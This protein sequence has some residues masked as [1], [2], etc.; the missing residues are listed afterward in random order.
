MWPS[1]PVAASSDPARTTPF[2][3]GQLLLG[4]I[5][6][7]TM[8]GVFSVQ[9]GFY[10]H[11][12]EQF[13]TACHAPVSEDRAHQLTIGVYSSDTIWVKGLVSF[14]LVLTI[15]SAVLAI[16]CTYLYHVTYFGTLLKRIFVCQSTKLK[17]L[18]D[19]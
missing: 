9:L 3:I 18:A 15:A 8:F 7:I 11:R 10:L 2:D 17:H 6:N 1:L 5:T 19:I 4:T 13:V 16:Y 14:Y 12:F